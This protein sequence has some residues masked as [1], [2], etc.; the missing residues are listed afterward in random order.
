MSQGIRDI[1]HQSAVILTQ[2]RPK[3]IVLR[4]K[5][6][7]TAIVGRIGYAAALTY[8]R[9][10]RCCRHADATQVCFLDGGSLFQS[11]ASPCDL[12]V[13]Q[14]KLHDLVPS[15]RHPRGELIH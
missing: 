4:T 3:L 6:L 7:N 15:N 11:L 2:D 14:A 12:E 10:V 9:T 13:S 5:I 1:S 8:D